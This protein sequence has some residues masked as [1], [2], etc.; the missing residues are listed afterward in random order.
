M[1]KLWESWEEIEIC[2][3]KDREMDPVKQEETVMW[4]KSLLHLYAQEL[5]LQTQDLK[6]CYRITEDPV[7]ELLIDR[8]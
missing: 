8:A 1:W 4:Q 5:S 3:L 7:S 2:R 6:L